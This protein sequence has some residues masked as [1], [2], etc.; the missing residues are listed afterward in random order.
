MKK[1]MK[2]S[3][4]PTGGK[5]TVAGSARDYLTGDWRSKRPV[6]DPKKCVNCMIC[7]MYCPENCIQVKNEKIQKFNYDYCKGCGICARECPFKAIHMED[8]E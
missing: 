7:W 3:E 2:S 8:E 1:A 5:I 6:H 4:I